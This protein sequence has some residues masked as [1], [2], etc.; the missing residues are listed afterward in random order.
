MPY[1]AMQYNTIQVH[2]LNP[3][4]LYKYNEAQYNT[5]HATQ[6]MQCHMKHNPCHP[7]TTYAVVWVFT[8]SCMG[9]YKCIAIH[10]CM[11]AMD[12]CVYMCIIIILFIY[13]MHGLHCMS[14]IAWVVL[15]GLHC[16]GCNA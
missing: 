4:N 10:R 8:Y 11:G 13:F 3:C 9:E 14:C 1:N 2:I 12:A 5:T 6:H 15:D 16:M 7:Y